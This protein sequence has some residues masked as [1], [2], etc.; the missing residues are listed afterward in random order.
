MR[1]EYHVQLLDINDQEIFRD[2]LNLLGI[3]GW[4]LV[5]V[6]PHAEKGGGWHTAVLKRMSR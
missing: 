4:E 6:V 2:A 5:S 1:W 3:D